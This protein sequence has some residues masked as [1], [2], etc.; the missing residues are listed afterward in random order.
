MKKFI[1]IW[2]KFGVWSLMIFVV[3]LFAFITPN[4]LTM[5]TFTNILRQGCI[6]GVCALGFS[7]IL[8]T[9]ETA[10][11]CGSIVG[12]TVVVGCKLINSGLSPVICVLAMILLATMLE[13]IDGV[14][15]DK[16]QVSAFLLTIATMSLWRGLALYVSEG[17]THAVEIAA[18]S[19]IGQSTLFGFLPSMVLILFVCLAIVYVLMNKMYFGRFLYAAGG[20][21]DAAI[22]SGINVRKVKLLTFAL[23]GVLYGISAVM[24][25]SRNMAAV[26]NMGL[27]YEFSC[28]TACVLGGISLIGG[29]G[30][31]Q[32]VLIGVLLL[33]TIGVGLNMMDISSWTETL[34]DGVILLFF[35]FVDKMRTK[36]NYMMLVKQNTK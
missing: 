34:I 15:C 2:D 8:I 29:S 19:K 22:L 10:L 14:L 23:A 6:L 30:K 20:N 1:K 3:I 35:Y 16:L 17:K 36:A 27:N 24:L 11:T 28:L 9:G 13:F 25:L 12:L 32:N 26:G 31:I 7:M 21:Y 4:F 5:N 18:F 33:G